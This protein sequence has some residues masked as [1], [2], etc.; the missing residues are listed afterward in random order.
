MIEVVTVE[1]PSLGDRSYLAHDGQLAVVVD[2]QRD[3][4]RML[5]VATERDVR[6]AWVL[7]THVHN[8]YVTGGWELARTC[9]A[10][11]ALPGGS[12]VEVE[13]AALADG[14]MLVIGEMRVRVLDTPGHTH[15][16]ASY[17]LADVGGAVQAVFTGG[18]MLYGATGRTDLVGPQATVELTHAQYRSVRRLAAELPDDATVLPTHGFGSFCSATPTS[19][20]TSTIGQQRRENV[21]LTLAEQ[22]YVD[23]LL[24]GL[25]AYPAYYAR[26]GPTNRHGPAPVD[27][28]PPKP[29]DP[30]ELRRR[31]EAGEWVVD[32]RARAAFA[33]GHLA[34]S[35][36]FDGGGQN[37]VTYLGW[38]YRIGT[39]LT[40]IGE[41]GEQVAHARR[42]LVRIGVDDL[43]GAATGDIDTL[44]DGRALRSYP[45]ADF[46]ALARARS[47]GPVPVLDARRNGERALG[48]VAGSVHIPLH[49]L[50]DRL[51][52]V[53][54]GE[55]WVYCGSGYRAS[56]AA[57]ILDRLGRQVVL[58]D[59]AYDAARAA[60]LEG[61]H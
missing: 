8:D 23:T 57:S 48:S 9:G 41:T 60:G 35:L 32:L 25:D 45:V 24:A 39:P 56:I 6:I 28:S 14:D 15:H 13:H 18:S 59:D 46:A 33:S 5:A 29:V 34:G 49:E 61:T 7:E 30:A 52:E 31:I 37:F 51:D 2:P 36:G 58:I 12:G 38:L 10:T 54:D 22:D 16:H 20:D 44:A 1:T 4:D 3:I 21:A 43:A 26:M 50:A 42:E 47:A 40:L 19:G 17:V 53:P 27:L 55:V 11:Y